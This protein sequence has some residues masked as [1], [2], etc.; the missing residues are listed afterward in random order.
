MYIGHQVLHQ[1][2][3]QIKK[4]FSLQEDFRMS[5]LLCLVVKQADSGERSHF[6]AR[7]ASKSPWV[8]VSL[9]SPV[10]KLY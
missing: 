1:N 2:Q 10:R 6:T 4:K 3:W 8:L 5:F 9:I 7:T